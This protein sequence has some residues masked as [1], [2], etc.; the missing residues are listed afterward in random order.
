MQDGGPGA[1]AAVRAARSRARAMPPGGEGA[2]K[3]KIH[4]DPI[5]GNLV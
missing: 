3:M 4:P 5:P 1:E 2:R